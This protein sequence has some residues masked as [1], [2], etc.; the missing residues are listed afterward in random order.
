MHFLSGGT[1]IL[2]S[3]AY[4][5]TNFQ[6]T[7]PEISFEHLNPTMIYVL[8]SLLHCKG[9]T[10]IFNKWNIIEIIEWFSI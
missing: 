9:S 4:C 2:K 1:K 8:Y 6:T 10:K 7:F 5:N 3:H